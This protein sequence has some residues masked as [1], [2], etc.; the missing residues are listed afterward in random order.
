MLN[1][2][3]LRMLHLPAGSAVEH[4]SAASGLVRVGE[5]LYVIADDEHVLGMFDLTD[6]KSGALRPLFAGGL[7]A[8]H[9]ARKAAKPDLEALTW[10]PPFA[11]HPQGALLALGSGSRSQRQRA[12]LLPLD[13][14]GELHG[15]AL[16]IDLSP[17]YAPLQQQHVQLNIEGAFVSGNRFCLLQRGNAATPM[18]ALIAFDW[19]ATVDWLYGK[20]PAPPPLST[21]RFMLGE[22][23]GVPL[24]FTDGAALPG[25]GWVFCAAAEA[26]DDNY[27]D[28]PCR[29][30]AVGLVADDGR[31]RGLW[32]VSLRCKIEG[33]AVTVEHDLLHL[34]LVTDADDRGTPAALLAATLDLSTSP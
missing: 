18:N 15:A 14:K 4:L 22:L 32:P 16:E 27:A 3:T 7:P 1:V 26:S 11:G 21:T 12:V 29:G 25:G 30:S 13:E 24:C 9:S 6:E 20:R 17:L 10:L 19:S 5:R 31:L 2:Q 23:D 33:I 28:G 34:L 8:T